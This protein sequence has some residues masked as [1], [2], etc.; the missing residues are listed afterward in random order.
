MARMIRQLD[1]EVL[2][3]P[4]NKKQ[5]LRLLAYMKPYKWQIAGSLLLM[6]IAMVC[7]LASPYLMSR[8]IGELQERTT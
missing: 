2:E 7:S 6:V 1:D 3:R 4:F 5:F 8:A